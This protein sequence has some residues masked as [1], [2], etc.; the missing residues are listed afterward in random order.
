MVKEESQIGLL[1]HWQNETIY[2][3]S[4]VVALMD[5]LGLRV[6][7][8]FYREIV[9]GVVQAL[10]NNIGRRE[11]IIPQDIKDL[12]Q[13]GN[14]EKMRQAMVDAAGKYENANRMYSSQKKQEE[15]RKHAAISL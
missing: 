1:V 8:K 12:I 7:E 4:I 9:S 15:Y 14:Q 10:L 5:Y 13:E 11:Q 3:G 6:D 2:W